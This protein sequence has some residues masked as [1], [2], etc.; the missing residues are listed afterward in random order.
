[1]RLRVAMPASA[2]AS[3]T[4]GKGIPMIPAVQTTFRNM[5]P[6]DAIKEQIRAELAKLA[7]FYG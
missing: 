4:I 2:S 5:R 1:M 3:T 7:T 6:Q